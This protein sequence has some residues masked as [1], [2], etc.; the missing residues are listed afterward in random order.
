MWWISK[1]HRAVY[2]TLI[3]LCRPGGNEK[4]CHAGLT[5][6]RGLG[7]DRT[8]GYVVSRLNKHMHDRPFRV[9]ILFRS[10]ANRLPQQ[11]FMVDNGSIKAPVDPSYLEQ[12][13]ESA[14]MGEVSYGGFSLNYIMDGPGVEMLRIPVPLFLFHFVINCLFIL[15]LTIRKPL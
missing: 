15:D 8:L 2:S 6:V 10:A 12:I 11:N 3:D 4:V 14:R 7:G 5:V 13:G 1:H 9:A